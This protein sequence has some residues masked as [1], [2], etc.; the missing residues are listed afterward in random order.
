MV[1]VYLSRGNAGP[2]RL[3]G[4]RDGNLVRVGALAVGDG[5]WIA[6]AVGPE[7]QAAV[8]RPRRRFCVI[9]QERAWRAPAL[10]HQHLLRSWRAELAPVL[11][12]SEPDIRAVT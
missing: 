2:V 9:A 4:W 8:C 12:D 7:H 6:A 11:Q 1:V 5:Q 10:R 3:V